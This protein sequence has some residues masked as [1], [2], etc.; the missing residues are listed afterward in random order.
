[1]K[2][3]DQMA[4]WYPVLT[5][6][7]EYVEEAQV[8][9]DILLGALGDGRH[10]LLELGAGAGH[11][12][13]YL[14]ADFDL[15]L[16]DLSPRM[17]EL[18]RVSCPGATF[19]VGDMRSLRLHRTFD[20]VFVHDALCYMLTE[21]DLAAVFATARAHLRPGGVLLLAPDFFAE[22]F[23]D[24]DE[25]GGSEIDGRSLRYL[26]WV[27]QR[28]GQKDRYVVDYAIMTRVGEAVPEVHHDRHEEGLFPRATWIRLLE[29]AGF[30]V[31]RRPWSHSDVERELEML[32]ASAR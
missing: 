29:A 18:A 13:H 14:A 28:E 21:A 5:P 9:R 17:I 30:V 15:T 26:A 7:E 25:V 1:M 4:D 16:T 12:A 8:F 19:A 20:A 32:L 23:E 31:E 10:T 11:N 24:G 2:L 27:W 6:L 3:Y 22:T